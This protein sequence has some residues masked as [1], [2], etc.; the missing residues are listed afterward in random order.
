MVI[1]LRQPEAVAGLEHVVRHHA[2]LERDVDP[3]QRVDQVREVL[4]AHLDDVVDAHAAAEEVLDRPHRQPGATDGVG[5]VDL[6][7]AVTGDRRVGVARDREPAYR[8]ERRVKQQDAVRATGPGG[9]GLVL[10]LGPLV[11]AEHEHRAA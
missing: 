9:A 8:P 3:A 6:L 5:G 11:R 7:R 4:E 1:A 2:A 10:A